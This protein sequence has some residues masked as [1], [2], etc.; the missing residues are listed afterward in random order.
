MWLTQNAHRV[1]FLTSQ[2][3]SHRIDIMKWINKN[4]DN[5]RFSIG[6]MNAELFMPPAYPTGNDMEPKTIFFELNIANKYNVTAIFDSNHENIN[7]WASIGLTVWSQN[8]IE[9]V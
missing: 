9:Y 4:I 2:D 7:I 6:S 1:V 5:V 3:E 8:S